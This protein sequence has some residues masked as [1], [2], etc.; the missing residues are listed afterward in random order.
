M[1]KKGARNKSA[2]KM[3]EDG[4]LV[5]EADQRDAWYKTCLFLIHV[6]PPPLDGKH[7]ANTETGNRVSVANLA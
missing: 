1:T 6:Q 7:V 3:E 5:L 4:Q 2:S